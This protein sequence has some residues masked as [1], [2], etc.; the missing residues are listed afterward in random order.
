MPR[1][2]LPSEGA[3]EV[4]D[5]IRRDRARLDKLE[6]P[7]GSQLARAL[8][9]VLQLIADL[10]SM[11]AAA[12]TSLGNL[13]ISGILTAT[14]VSS[15]G[16]VSTGGYLFTP[17]GYG[18]DITYTRRA[19]WLGSDGRLAWASSSRKRK[20][21]IRP[22]LVDPLAVLQVSS[23]LFQYRA[24]VAKRDDPDSPDYVGPEYVVVWEFG[25][26]AEELDE[27]GLDVVVDY[28]AD[29]Q[30]E[31]INYAMIGLLAIEASKHVWE[32]HQALAERVER[33]ERL[34]D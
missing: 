8:E 11:V 10:P 16:D 32:Q 12:I 1:R 34:L 14:G 27:L 30:P 26:I 24:E 17:A 15:S 21:S 22:S 7:D 9:K 20:A 31:G 13:T 33:L 23:K 6:Q 25:A 29:G 3:G 5:A 2:G 28:G 19:A 4:V 18:Y